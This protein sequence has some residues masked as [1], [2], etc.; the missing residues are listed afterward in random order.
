MTHGAFAQRP[1]AVRHGVFAEDPNELEAYRAGIIYALGPRD[2]IEDSVAAAIAQQLVQKRRLVRLEV[3]GLAIAG[4]LGHDSGRNILVDV[5]HAQRWVTLA[6]DFAGLAS[7]TAVGDYPDYQ[8]VTRFVEERLCLESVTPALWKDHPLETSADWEWALNAL[9]DHVWGT[10]HSEAVLWADQQILDAYRE[11]GQIEGRAVAD[12]NDQA[13][14]L[15]NRVTTYNTR[16]QRVLDGLLNQYRQLQ[17]R[18]VLR[19]GVPLLPGEELAP[20]PDSE[21]PL[22]LPEHQSHGPNRELPATR[23]TRP[24]RVLSLEEI[25]ARETNPIPSQDPSG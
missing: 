22:Q 18:I 7:G 17:T 21:P 4:T 11:L 23:R 5:Q 12:M 2:A 3:D 19:P 20:A 8:A 13:L 1:W 24:V 15:F 9:L 14:Q 16:I 10:D 6:Q 25:K